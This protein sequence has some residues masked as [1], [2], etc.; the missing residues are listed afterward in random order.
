MCIPDGALR[1]RLDGDLAAA[2][3][4]A[5]DNHLADCAGCRDR[6]EALAE[7]AG[8][9]QAL[10]GELAPPEVSADAHAAWTRFL[11]RHSGAAAQPSWLSRLFA[12]RLAPACGALAVL[13]LAVLLAF[14]SE[15][16]AFA[17]KLLGLFR[18][19]NIA[20][21]SLDRRPVTQ[22]QGKV[23]GQMLS[24]S[25]VVTKEGK[26]QPVSTR[27]EASRLASF[28]VRLLSAR[29]DQPRLTVQ[30]EHAFQLTVEMARVQA[31]LNLVGRP[32]LRF[33]DALN[34]AKVAVNI[35]SGVVAAYGDCPRR[36]HDADAPLP[37]ADWSNCVTVA[38]F[39]SPT[40]VTLPELDIA[41]IA[42]LALQLGGLTAEEARAFSRTVDWTSTLVI[43][44]PRDVASFEYVEVEGVR[45]VLIHHRS[46]G[47]RPA[48][49]ALLWT[50]NGM[51][52]SLSGFG[53]P[54]YAVP[55][56]N[57]LE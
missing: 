38:Q 45:G 51:V 34:G 53:N 32:D 47:N 57:S 2:D 1:A 39:P 7:R 48:S 36:P 27:A 41:P 55:L 52:H 35:P 44:V 56:A 49:Y 16:R 25:V 42:E 22:E 54:S 43:P 26:P 29:A 8:R 12:G 5:V 23:L 37:P 21:V 30:G 19:R 6:S 14:S 15:T 17:Q 28:T 3:A 20:V 46:L 50:K 31:L 11:A 10:L 4:L 40:V 13:T 18:V 9:V 24:E 33:P